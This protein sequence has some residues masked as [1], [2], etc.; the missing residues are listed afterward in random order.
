LVC[1]DRVI[2]GE[3]GDDT[4]GMEQ[5]V[6]SDTLLILLDFLAYFQQQHAQSYKVITSASI[7]PF[8][9]RFNDRVAGN[10]VLIQI[11]Q[12]FTWDA[13]QI[14]QTGATIPPSVDGL[15]LYDFC[16]PS[17]IARLTPSQVAC[18]EAEYGVT[19][20]DGTVTQ[21]GSPFFTVASGATYPLITRLDGANSLGSFNAG[22]KTL[23]FTS[24]SSNLQINGAQS[25]IIPGNSTFN[26]LAKLDGVAGGVYNAGLD[27]LNFTTTPAI[28]QRNAIQIKTLANASTFNL[29]TKLDGSANNGTWD[30]VDTL[31]FTSAACSP[32]TFQINAVNK[33]S[34]TSG[35]T[36]NLITKLD[37]AVNSGSYDAPTDTL[38]FT[39]AACSPVALQINGTP[40]E[41]LASGSTFNLI[42]TLDG[43]PSGTYNAATDTLAFTS[44]GGWVRPS[45]W[46][47]LPTISAATE[48][49]NIL[50]LVYENRLNRFTIQINH[51]TITWGDGTS[52]NVGGS[53][54]L[55]TKTYTYSTLA[56]TVYVDALTGENYKFVII[57][58]A[59]NGANITYVD[60]SVSAATSP[61][62]AAN[63]AVDWDLSFPNC[64]TQFHLSGVSRDAVYAKQVKI[65]ALGN[66]TI[67]MG[68][69]HNLESLQLPAARLG[70]WQ[71]VLSGTGPVRVTN[72]DW[73]G[74]TSTIQ[75]FSASAILSHGNLSGAS[76]TRSDYY[77]S[78]CISLQS[79]GTVNLPLC[80]AMTY[81]FTG[82]LALR[83]IGLITVPNCTDYS[84]AFNSC[85][86]LNAIRFANSAACTNTTGMITNCYSLQ[87]LDMPN[88]TRGVNF[89]NTSM[90]NY[91]M[92]IFANGIG[93]ASGA[94]TITIT[95]TPFGALVTA[96][97]ATA[98]AIRLVMTTKGYTI[99]N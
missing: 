83:S 29:I 97:D 14:P 45:F 93:T 17:V 52:V 96:S 30:G 49:G 50:L 7:D 12:P 76:M 24:N 70:N 66:P 90:G 16:D 89:V 98:L 46:P 88:L 60:F 36:F 91:G 80:T 75:V 3:E 2:T 54:P 58:I 67:R 11:R 19:C 8:T 13:C 18:L 27:T 42:A 71:P 23:S 65:W 32:V 77:V 15:T 64:N 4:A 35:T 86:S 34:I 95:G 99:A 68:R 81:M 26:L 73:T 74:A 28:L 10:S 9:E 41:S 25:E 87:V 63:Y 44:T 20:L 72:Q 84:N 1:A 53:T 37:G 57:N 56:G 40:S 61:L 31:D 55:T 78:D 82:C 79:F 47:T 51:S 39:S 33:E 85:K 92:N 69:M 43:T 59:R 48:G 94:Q 5:E 22:T 6:L 38:S 21:N 62:N